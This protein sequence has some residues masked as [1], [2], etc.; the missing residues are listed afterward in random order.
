MMMRLVLVSVTL[1][2]SLCRPALAQ[3][4]PTPS[5]LGVTSPLGIGPAPPVTPPGIPPGAT[6][7]ASPGLSSMIVAPA[8]SN[9]SGASD[10][11]IGAP[12]ASSSGSATLFDGGAASGTTSMNC[13]LIPPRFA[14]PAASSSSPTGMVVAPVSPLQI[15][16]GATELGGGGLS[17][18]PPIT[19]T[20][21]STTE[22]SSM[23]SPSSSSPSTGSGTSV[24]IP[25]AAAASLSGTAGELGIT[26][27]TTGSC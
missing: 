7:L 10:T 20:P 17:S 21:T 23:S 5:P 13:G 8:I 26:C 16:L 3:V 1:V 25:A 24:P 2:I 12:G 9:C 18:I 22:A 27:A 11:M 6:E 15:P 4:A 19:P 14:Q